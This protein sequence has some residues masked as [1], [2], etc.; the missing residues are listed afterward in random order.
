MIS[1]LMSI[2]NEKKV[3]VKDAISSILNQTY[4]DFEVII[5]VDNPKLSKDL[6]S[7]LNFL[8][9]ND[10]RI[11]IYFNETNIGLAMS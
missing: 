7:Y 2:Y 6:I 1:V 5:I 3:W 9:E 10:S 8:A 4:Q 11:K